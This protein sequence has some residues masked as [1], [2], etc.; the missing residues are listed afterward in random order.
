MSLDECRAELTRQHKIR[1]ETEWRS[2]AYRAGVRI[3]EL[4]H[5]RRKLRL[6]KMT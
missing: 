5:L 1:K 4:K 2:V 6:E 3:R